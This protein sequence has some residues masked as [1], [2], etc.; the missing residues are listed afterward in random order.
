MLTEKKD[1]PWMRAARADVGVSERRDG[2]KIMGFAKAGYIPVYESPKTPW[3]AVW[4]CAKLEDAGL[5]S[6]RNATARSFLKWGQKLDAPRIGCVVVLSRG[7]SSWQGHVGFYDGDAGKDYIWLV[8]GNMGDAVTRQKFLKSTVLKNGYRWPSEINSVVPVPPKVQDAPITQPT[9]DE[10][11]TPVAVVVPATVQA[12]TPLPAPMLQVPVSVPP[13]QT[14]KQAVDELRANGSR[15]IFGVDRIIS[16]V[17]AAL[18]TIG[19]GTTTEAVVKAQEVHTLL[20]LVQAMQPIMW[21]ILGVIA[22]AILYEV[23]RIKDAR[24][25]DHVNKQQERSSA[26]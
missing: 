19:I 22:V 18:A 8:S 9:P 5:K 1:P 26:S 4:T 3:C 23:T 10:V 17:R 2:K 14:E 15:T 25:D 24:V 16:Y 6:T 7:R 21:T 11:A 12:P 13:P 20:P